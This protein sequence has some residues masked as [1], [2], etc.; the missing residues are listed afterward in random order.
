MPVLPFERRPP[1]RYDRYSGH[2]SSEV[3]MSPAV[4]ERD[5]GARVQ[6]DSG[7][8]LE[9]LQR[10]LIAEM[11]DK[12][13]EEIT[14]EFLD[15]YLEEHVYPTARYDVSSEYGGYDNS[16]LVVRT[17]TEYKE[18]EESVAAARER[19]RRAAAE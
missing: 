10:R 5:A 4:S 12:R 15:Q 8:S 1:K 18:I 13:P 11:L 14:D 16:H 3:P 19:L 6:V 7:E 17:R 2:L 9:H